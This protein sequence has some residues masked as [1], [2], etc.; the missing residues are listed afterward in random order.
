MTDFLIW[1]FGGL[2]IPLLA[3]G[4]TKLR[5]RLLALSRSR[6]VKT[7]TFAAGSDPYMEDFYKFFTK[8]IAN[9]RQSVYITGEGFEGSSDKG[10]ELALKMVES[11]RHALNGGAR[12]IRLQTRTV[13]AELWIQQ[14][15]SLVADYPRSF[16]LYVL[17]DTTETQS[18]SFCAIDVDDPSRNVAELMLQIPRHLGSRRHNVAGTAVFVEGHQVLALAIRDRIVEMAKDVAISIPLTTPASVDSFFLG[19]YY[20]AYGSNMGLRQM[21]SR[22]PSAI[23]VSV[24]AL[25]DHRIVFNRKGTYRPGGVASVAE[26]PGERVYGVVWKLSKS[27]FESLDETEDPKAYRRTT[28]LVHTLAGRPY[29]CHIYIAF[30]NGPDVP[31]SSYLEELIKVAGESEL[32]LEYVAQLEARRSD[33]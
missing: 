5:P 26:A 15:R 17:F 29:E 9:A 13:L 31:D 4:F 1:M 25:P 16:E 12:V 8:K 14:L 11:M 30:P 32:P 28:V 2:G 10:G 7:I 33:V 23:M 20:F 21:I 22:C 27:D 24:A 18:A 3:F 6:R 19:E